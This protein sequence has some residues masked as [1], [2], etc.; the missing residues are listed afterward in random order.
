M[1]TPVLLHVL[2]NIPSGMTSSLSG[3]KGVAPAP[4]IL[5]DLNETLRSAISALK[6]DGISSRIQQ[7][8]PDGNRLPDKKLT[9]LAAETVDL[10]AEIK[11]MLEPGI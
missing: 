11:H 9:K 5:G 6:S 7:E 10:V 4:A 3:T 2:G 1:F 8:L